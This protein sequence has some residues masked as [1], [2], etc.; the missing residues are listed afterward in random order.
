MDLAS[1]THSPATV[2]LQYLAAV[3]CGESRALMLIAGAFSCQSWNDFMEKYPGMANDITSLARCVVA[4]VYRRVVCTF[5]GED[6]VELAAFAD[7]RISVDERMRRAKNYLDKPI[8]CVGPLGIRVQETPQSTLSVGS[9]V[10][11]M[12]A[13]IS[14]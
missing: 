2:A 5:Q 8:C 10:S 11:T 1:P 3:I 14:P 9:P 6:R 13:C 4:W 12:L 7:T